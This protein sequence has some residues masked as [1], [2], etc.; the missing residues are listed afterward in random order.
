[1]DGNQ[2]AEEKA[3]HKRCRLFQQVY[4]QCPLTRYEAHVTYTTI[5]LPTMTYPLPATTLSNSTLKKAQSSTT[6]IILSKMGYNRNMP[7]TIVYAP[8]SHGG[9][10]FRHLHTEQG[11]QKVLHTIK[12]LRSKT[13]LSR[14]LEANIQAYQIQS[15]LEHSI[16]EDTQPLPWMSN[17]WITHL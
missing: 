3:L 17:R 1:M 8:N 5:F 11:V 14:L 9:L 10:G 6:P 13:S 16:L 7:K 4:R 2:K 12:H 15:G